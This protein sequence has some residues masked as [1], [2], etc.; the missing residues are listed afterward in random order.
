[1]SADWT[2]RA[3]Q[4]SARAIAVGEPTAWFDELYAAGAA[5]EISLPWE[6]DEPHVLL[7]EWAQRHGLRGDGDE[8]SSSVAGSAP[9]PSTSPRWASPPRRSTCRGPPYGWPGHGTRTQ[10]S[11]TARPTCGSCRASGPAP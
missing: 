5:G 8:A 10:R 1:M 11:T 7:R 9:T 6:R 3:D 2:A 4:L